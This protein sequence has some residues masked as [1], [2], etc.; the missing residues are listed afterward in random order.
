MGSRILRVMLK[1]SDKQAKFNFDFD[2]IK[3]FKCLGWRSGFF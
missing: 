3:A 2:T 1:P